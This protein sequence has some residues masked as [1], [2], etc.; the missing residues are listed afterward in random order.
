MVSG[1]DALKRTRFHTAPA[2]LLCALLCALLLCSCAKPSLRVPDNPPLPPPAGL[3]AAVASDLH[4][5]PDNTDKSGTPAAAAYNLELADALLRDARQQGAEILLLTGDL[6]NGGKPHRHEALIEK[7][8]RAEEAGLAVYVLPGNHDL[9]PIGQQD[10][11]ALYADFGYGEAASRDPASL[12]YCVVREDAALLM[13][14]TGGYPGG[15][16]DLPAASGRRDGEACL[17]EATLRWI[18]EQLHAA[19][20]KGLPVLCA[21]H[22]NLL[23]PES[24]DSEK[25][26][27]YLENGDRLAALLR[28][29]GVPLYLS[30]H[31]HV[32]AVLEEDGLTELITEYLLAY[33]VGYS[34][35]DLERDGLTVTHR[36]V[37]VNAWAAENGVSDPVLRDFAV[38]QQRA[39]YAYSRENVAYMAE[40]NP[41]SRR[42]QRQAA[43]FF[44]AVMDAFWRGDLAAER[45]T[46]RAM[47]GCEPFFRCAEGYAYGWW[48]RDL[49]ENASGAFS[50]FTI[51]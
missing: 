2:G 44:Y 16:I 47:P 6:V 5:D 1:G 18:E 33:P 46:L 43:A 11:A 24:R 51:P 23:P 21:G 25:S 9:A 22:F 3:R 8:R 48:L 15:V 7:L 40:R 12:S 32:R 27:Y 10:F 29:Y 26:G 37:D 30:G 41:L 35:V 20:E 4:L 45:E 31:L 50:G 19:R 49:I 14:D 13:L 42:E 38:W 36:R 39:L 17:S 28:E 34:V